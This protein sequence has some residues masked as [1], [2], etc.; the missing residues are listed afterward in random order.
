MSYWV[1]G[2]LE[3]LELLGLLGYWAIELIKIL[4]KAQ[5]GNIILKKALLLKS[6]RAFL[7]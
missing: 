3:L 1:I 2:L 6:Q 4:S 5:D 7:F